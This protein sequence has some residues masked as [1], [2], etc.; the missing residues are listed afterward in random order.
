MLYGQVVAI[1]IDAQLVVRG[2]L[3]KGVVGCSP[4]SAQVDLRV[5]DGAQAIALFVSEVGFNRPRVTRKAGH[6]KCNV[7][8][9]FGYLLIELIVRKSHARYLGARLPEQKRDRFKLLP[10]VVLLT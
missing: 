1:R 2:Q 7:P 8:N 5:D 3:R 6:C 10:R 9:K 4:G